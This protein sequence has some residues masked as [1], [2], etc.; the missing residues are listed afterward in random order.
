MDLLE[1]K[2]TILE[3]LACVYD[4]REEKMTIQMVT[5]FIKDKHMTLTSC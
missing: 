2:R 5:T 4:E 1:N 3:V